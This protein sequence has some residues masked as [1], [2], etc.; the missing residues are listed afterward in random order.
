MKLSRQGQLGALWKGAGLVNVREQPLVIEQ[1][2]TSFGD[3]WESF[4]KG[5]GPGGAYVVSLPTERRQMLEMRMKKRLLGNR[6]DGSF[7][8][9][10]RAWCVRGEVPQAGG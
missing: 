4:L 7:V 8:L 2:F 3:Y 10:A 1:S 9:G 6:D 5:A